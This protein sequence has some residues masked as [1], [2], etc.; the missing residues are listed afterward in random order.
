MTTKKLLDKYYEG[1]ARKA[2]WESGLADDMRFIGGD[3]TKTEP[4]IGKQNYV[5]IVQGLSRLFSTLRVLRTFVDGDQ[6]MV[7]VE[8]DWTFPKGVNIPGTVAEYWKVK[9][10]KLWELTIFFD[11]GTFE[12]LTKG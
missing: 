2:D 11:T 10:G 4:T 5:R 7:V 6:A 1:L 9:D 3:M 8:Y 12:R